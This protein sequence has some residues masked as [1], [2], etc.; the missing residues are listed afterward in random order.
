MWSDQKYS[1]ILLIDI[2]V[3]SRLPKEQRN[4]IF[5]LFSTKSENIDFALREHN[6]KREDQQKIFVNHF[7]RGAA[8]G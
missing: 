5:H 3:I 6:W 7:T 2:I 8:L 4:A 1:Y